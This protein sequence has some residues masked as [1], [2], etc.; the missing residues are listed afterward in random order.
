MYNLG[1]PSSL[2]CWKN[3][4]TIP[5]QLIA[6]LDNPIPTLLG[7]PDPPTDLEYSVMKVSVDLQ[8]TRPSYSGGVPVADYTVSANNGIVTGN[9]AEDDMERVQYSALVYGGVNITTINS[10]GQESTPATINIPASG[11][12]KLLGFYGAKHNFSMSFG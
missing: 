6:I 2:L 1:T 7:F 11:T 12:L 4:H 8:W 10:C 3:N 5:K 9:I